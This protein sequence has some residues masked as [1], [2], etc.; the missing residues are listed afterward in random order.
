MQLLQTL[1]SHPIIVPLQPH[2]SMQIFH[3]RHLVPLTRAETVAS[4]KLA[5]RRWGFYDDAKADKSGD[6]GIVIVSHSNGVLD[7]GGC[8]RT[9]LVY[10][11]EARLLIPFAFV[12][13]KERSAKV[14]V[15]DRRGG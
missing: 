14:S 8:S 11:R 7:M 4:I 2:I 15:T 12:F 13:G 3:P 1:P 5:C 6:E 9:V 10:Q